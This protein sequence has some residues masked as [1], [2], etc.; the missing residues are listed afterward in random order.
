[1]GGKKRAATARSASPSASSSKRRGT[2]DID[3][4]WSSSKSKKN[5]K[6]AGGSNEG[7]AIRLFEELADPD[8]PNTINMEGKANAQAGT[9]FMLQFRTVLS[10]RFF[11]AP[12]QIPFSDSN[13]R[14]M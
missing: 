2:G 5:K 14:H 7:S 12:D 4:M 10:S 11:S 9:C 6:T 13:R 3:N 1:M 8:D